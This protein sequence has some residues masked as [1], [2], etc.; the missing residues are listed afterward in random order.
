MPSVTNVSAL[1]WDTSTSD[2]ANLLSPVVVDF[3]VTDEYD[4][5][6]SGIFSPSGKINWANGIVVDNLTN[7][8][9][10]T[11][12]VGLLVET[13]P[14]YQKST[15]GLNPNSP[16]VVV[17]GAG[18][19]RLTFFT[20]IYKG[21]PIG[22]NTLEA[23]KLAVVQSRTGIV[24]M[25]PGLPNTIPSGTLLCVGTE[26]SRSVYPDLF[27]VIGIRF[28]AGDGVTTFNLP[29]FSDR[30]PV[31]A[32]VSYNLAATGGAKTVSLTA[33]QN[34]QH[35]HGVTDSGHVHGVSDPGHNHVATAANYTH[36]HTGT[37]SSDTHSHTGTTTTDAHTHTFPA[38]NASFD[39][40]TFSSG[41]DRIF[42]VQPVD[43]DTLAAQTTSSD[44]HN[45][46]FTTSSD[47]HSHTLTLSS[48]THTHT[49][50]VNSRVTGLTVNTVTTGI[51]INN[52]GTGAAHENMPPYLGV[53]FIIWT[54]TA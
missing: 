39:Q 32:G 27:N 15:I 29:N 37:T 9:P 19:A 49:V 5:Q 11:V 45:H 6:P 52:S 36:T 28:G 31:G 44:S 14:A 35:S 42:K 8:F 34:G 51:T 3:D 25:W 54:G 53:Y 47:T 41:G 30:M 1:I 17:T 48:D 21:S 18:L 2:P 22:T 43:A 50:T 24:E 12:S 40:S 10:I 20:G 33:N 7:G 23:Y 38:Y 4:I 46:T 13:V 26:V 16:Q